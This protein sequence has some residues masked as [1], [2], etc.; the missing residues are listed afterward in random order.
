MAHRVDINCDMGES[1]GVYSIGQDSQIMQYIT[2]ANIACGFHAGDPSVMRNTVTLALQHD[3][4]VGAHPGYPDLLG[5]G[6]R[7]MH[8]TY[9][10]AR[11]AVLYQLGSLGAFA[12]AL[13]TKIRHMKAHGVL[14]NAA[15]KD[16]ELARALADAVF[17]Y[18]RDIIFVA[19]AGSLLVDAGR[20][21]GLRVASEA[22]ADR[23]YQSDGSLVPRGTPGAVIDDETLVAA[24]VARMLKEG[25]VTSIDGHELDIKPDTI[26]VHGDTPGAVQFA[27]AMRAALESAGIEVVPLDKMLS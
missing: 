7:Y 5:F 20:Q 8:M 23:A 27:R 1:F 13:G 2:S 18:D 21:A 10:E 4:S 26:C 24:R 16:S 11:D 17:E 22:F 3:V 19:L 9:R 6:R 25:K 15:A 12:T 14:Y